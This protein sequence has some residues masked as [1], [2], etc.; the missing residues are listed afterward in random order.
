MLRILFLILCLLHFSDAKESLY[1]NL[2]KDFPSHKV[3]SPF[4]EELIHLID[5]AQKEIVFAIYGLR[6]QSDI[7]DALKKAKK[8]GVSVKGVVDSDSHGKNYYTHTDTLY[9]LFEI[10]SD[11]KS[12][13]MHNKFFV[14]D[15]KILWSGSSN[16]SDTGTGGYN[17]NAVVVIEDKE[18]AKAYIKEFKQMFDGKFGRA[19]TEHSY[20]NIRTQTSII[21][22]YF[23]PKSHTYEKAIRPLIQGAKHSI[24]VPI[25]YL[26][27]EDLSLEL[28]K[29]SKRGVEVKV[30]LDA[31][32]AQNAYS[33]HEYL[34]EQGIKVKVE[35]F[36][37]KMH[38]KSMIIDERYFIAGSMNF[39]K[40]GNDTNDE[41]TLII[42]NE[43]LAKSYKIYFSAL[44]DTIPNRF[45]SYNP[46]PEG[47]ESHNACFDGID[48][49]FD[50]K[51]DQ[52]DP[53][54]QKT[55]KV[56][57]ASSKKSYEAF[58]RY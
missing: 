5:G 8:R 2:P 13:I 17:A 41:N 48:N 16:I 57:H 39:T 52:E 4:G 19:K 31:S 7:L 37:G 54:C 53:S 11:H 27:H 15:Q 44:W 20:T 10:R 35:N 18:V 1:V 38:A 28:V 9:E 22:I 26:T 3:Q 23:S 45:L 42:A 36:G 40:A 24:Y 58:T 6:E 34:R 46:L 14:F 47:L 56:V 12:A 55:L 30:I 32:A 50:G 43:S 33:K 21:S 51:K 29:A 25:F 49:D